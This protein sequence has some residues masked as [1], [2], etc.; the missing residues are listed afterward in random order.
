MI[1]SDKT[2]HVAVHKGSALHLVYSERKTQR[3]RKAA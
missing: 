3:K 2:D 1:K